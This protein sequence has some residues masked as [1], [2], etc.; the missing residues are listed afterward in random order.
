MIGKSPGLR[1]GLGSGGQ[2]LSLIAEEVV[3]VSAL[4]PH[5]QNLLVVRHLDHLIFLQ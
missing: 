5:Q 4:Q 3:A 2:N 1:G